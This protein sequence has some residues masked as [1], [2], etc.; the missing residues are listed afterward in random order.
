MKRVQVGGCGCLLS[1]L[2]LAVAVGGGA[3]LLLSAL[4][5]ALGWPAVGVLALLLAVFVGSI[6]WRGATAVTRGLAVARAQRPYAP[7]RTKLDQ[8]D[9]LLADVRSGIVRVAGDETSVDL[10]GKLEEI[11][12]RKERIVEGLLELDAFL[13]APGNEEH[14]LVLDGTWMRMRS[15][16]AREEIRTTLEE[17]ARRLDTVHDAVRT[18]KADREAL[19][20][21][22][23]GIAIALKEL[24]ARL[25]APSTDRAT[26]A[27]EISDELSAL[28]RALDRLDVAR[29]EIAA[30]ERPAASDTVVAGRVQTAEDDP[31]QPPPRSP[32]A[33]PTAK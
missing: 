32:V 33:K 5:G 30:T 7:Y 11:R 8:I 15:K 28:S 29:A 16:V 27:R 4:V 19:L 26:L 24:R 10:R 6:A 25:I 18:V 20:A 13:S 2:A 3:L 31:P 14:R 1:A 22:L 9:S 21:H 17:N 12:S 23:D